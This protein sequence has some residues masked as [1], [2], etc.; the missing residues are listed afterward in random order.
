MGNLDKL[1]REL[2]TLPEETQWVEFKHDNYNPNM[3]GEDISALANGAALQDKE[4]A[5]FV[6]GIQNE[7]HEI[8][9]TDYDLRSLKK[10]NEELENWL[11]RLLSSHADFEYET[12]MMEGET[13]GIMTIKAAE[14]L[15]VSFEKQEFIRIG[16]YTKKLKDYP[17]VQ[18]RLWSKLQ[19]KK[20]E[21]QVARQ[22]L[23]ADEVL[24]L[25]KYEVYFDL[26]GVP[27]PVSPDGILHYLCEDD[28]VFK[29]DNGLY[30]ITNL[31]AILLAKNFRTSGVYLGKQFGLS[32]MRARTG[33]TCFGKAPRKTAVMRSSLMKPCSTLTQLFRQG[34]S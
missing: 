12:V 6:W 2:M 7:T 26:V 3:I 16:S 28:I 8:V 10:G 30:G 1:V 33:R 13:V 17:A 21:E 32:S 14:N 23:S 9:G 19:N 31:G 11:R 20:F 25:L 15:P 18:G 27:R 4:Y 24:K 29:Q 22:D 5:Y 34:R